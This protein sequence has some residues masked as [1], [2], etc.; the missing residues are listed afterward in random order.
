MKRSIL[1]QEEFLSA[2]TV[3]DIL[4]LVH[5]V[6][7]F[8]RKCGNCLAVSDIVYPKLSRNEMR[9]LSPDEQ[10]SFMLYLLEPMDRCKFSVLL[11]LATGMRIGEI[12]ALRWKN[13]SIEE[14]TVSVNS[15]MQRLRDLSE[16][17]GQKT[18][19]VI[20]E[21]KSASGARII[22]LTEHMV[23]LC[24]SYRCDDPD[25]FV[26]TGVADRYFEPRALQYRFS[27]YTAACNLKGVHF[28][29]L[30][31]T[32]ATRCVELDFEL[33]SLSEILGHASP[34]ITLDRYVH[35]SLALKRENMNKLTAIG[36]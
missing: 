16:N 21:P 27:K 2:K 5:S 22:P 17:K 10:Q 11:A 18:K 7:D 19:I 8:A 36:L 28:H 24:A 9:V 23:Q 20:G 25:A 31:H 4:T 13:I 33:K 14:R 30:R 15:T 1:L 34:R 32:F 6:L 29:S 35:S 3:K 26:L 12:C